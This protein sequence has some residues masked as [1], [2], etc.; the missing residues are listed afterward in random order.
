MSNHGQ[1]VYCIS[2]L[3]MMWLSLARATSPSPLILI[4]TYPRPSQTSILHS[5]LSA[6]SNVR[7]LVVCAVGRAREVIQAR[8]RRTDGVGV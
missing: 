1:S 7:S 6:L 8:A 4:Q 5:T 3:L 2:A